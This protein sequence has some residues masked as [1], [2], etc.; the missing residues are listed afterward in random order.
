MTNKEIENLKKEIENLIQQ[1]WNKINRE[2]DR[3]AREYAQE[4]QA[5]YLTAQLPF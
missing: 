4:Q 1:C 3:K 2:L 5:D